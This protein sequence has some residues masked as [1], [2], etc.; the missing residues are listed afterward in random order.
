MDNA[1]TNGK[2]STVKQLVLSLPGGLPAMPARRRRG[3]AGN[4]ASAAGGGGGGAGGG[5]SNGGVAAS[6]CSCFSSGPDE[7]PEI[8]YHVVENGVVTLPPPPLLTP[9]HP[10]PDEA[11]LNAKFAELVDELDLTAAKKEVMFNLPSEKKW[12]LYLSKKTEQHDTTSSHFPDYYIERVN[13]MSMLLFPREEEEVNTRA[14]LLDNLKTA[15]RT[16]PNSFVTRFLDQDGLICLLNFLVG[17]D[18]NTAQS[19]IHTSLIGCVKALMNNSNG[20]AHVLAH[21]TAINT[22]AQSLSTENIKTKIAVLEI[23][24]AMCLVPGG[25]RKVLEAMLHF[26]KHAYE[27]T[28]FQT[29]LN[30]LDRSTGV[31]K[32]E[33]NLKTAIMSFV[34]AILNYGPG[35]EH[36]EFRLHLRYEFL[37]LGIQPIIEKLRGHENA[38][39][40]RHLDIF[41]MVRIEDE[42]ELARKFDMAHI[43]TKSCTAMV[44]AIKKKLCMTPAYPHFLS[45][46]HH[47]LLIPYIGG[48]AE[49]WILFDRIV[50]QIVVQGENGENYDIA[51]IEINVK[52]I[53]KELATEEELRIAKENADKF[54]KENIELATQI[55]KKEQELEQSTQE[56]EDLQTTLAK[57][58]DKL[59]RETVSHL[60]D[61]QK[62]EELEYRIREMTQKL[63]SE[64]RERSYAE[65]TIR[66]GLP[67]DSRLSMHRGSLPCGPLHSMGTPPPPPPPMPSNGAPPAPPPL[68]GMGTAPPPPPCPPPSTRTPRIKN[69]PQPT[70]PLKSFNW[71]KLPEAR[72][73]GT[74]WTELDDTKLYKDIDLADIDRTF[75]AYQKQ[76]GCGTNGSLED[77]PALTCR[78]P[79]V[80]ELSLIDGRRAQNC[81]ILLSKLRLTNDEICRAILSMDSK[82]QLPKD[83]VEQLL[84]FLPSPEEKVLLE[85]HSSEMESMAKADRF[86]YEISRII[87]YEQRLRTLYY[88]KKFQERVSDCKPKIVAVL[89]ASKEVQ[90]S[91]RLKKL[92]E[93]VLAF[94]NYM[95]RGQ[96]GNAVGFKLSSLNHLAD[97]KSSTN[98]NYTLLHYLIETLEKKF[99]DTLKLEED[100]HHVKR[101]AKVNLGELEREIRD[102]KTGLNEVQK[103]LDFL[104]GQ[105]AQPGDKF[106]LVM[107]EFITGATYKFSELEDSFLDMKSRYE[108][109]ARR[110][111]EDPVQVPPDEFF[112]IFDSFLVSF[113]EAKNDNENFRR[114][115]EDEERRSR[116]EAEKRERKDGTLRGL[117]ALRA[118][119]SA[120][121][122]G[123]IN[124]LKAGGPA[125]LNGRTTADDKGEFDDLISAL[126]TGDV[127]GD[128][129]SKTRRNRRRGSSPAAN[130]AASLLAENGHHVIVNGSALHDTSRDRIVTRKLKS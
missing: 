117:A 13:A 111:G 57:T 6:L 18:Y 72:V 49:H 10:M 53:L 69:I 67:D 58:K 45:L 71:S 70:N 124:S 103:E 92:L 104:R 130:N 24:G 126:R 78:S 44:E 119:G 40:D 15:L 9:T 60:E 97:T 110:F 95:N 84:K 113:N 39:L 118:N 14:K 123:S 42:K 101:A 114:K 2:T 120:T 33:V 129:F 75:S 37:M 63:D 77:I 5:K 100:I 56:K 116:Q 128:E 62:I 26:Q 7:P 99:K 121:L 11:E 36:L 93:V 122:N 32:D 38:T 25:H 107:K 65:S 112:S 23:L 82:D 34:N 50:Q 48:S 30:D 16:Q 68:P 8:T 89:E 46:L 98:R 61:K 28:R 83:M 125:A 96:R 27:R 91:K 81:T 52:K 106:V 88:K 86:L 17:M 1:S 74:V 31:Y 127:F 64:R 94:G 43:D 105:P 29:V 3:V 51:P 41:D 12:Q 102:L 47:A 76:Q 115:K 21:P 54:E 35:Q 22:I 80:R 109:T 19:P 90:R 59:E 108:K 4:R 55:V 85:E 20:R 87:H 66:N 73:D 79:R